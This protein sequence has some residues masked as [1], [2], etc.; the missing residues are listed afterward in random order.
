M[1]FGGVAEERLQL[2]E[3]TL[4]SGYPG[5]RDLPLDVRKDLPRVTD[6]IA[7]RQFAEADRLVTQK[8]LGASWACYQPLGDLFFAFEHQ[9]S[10]TEY[11]REL[12][13]ANAVCRVRYRAGDVRFTREIFAS[14]PDEVIVVR[15]TAD[16]PGRLNF[17]LWLTS[18]HPVEVRADAARLVMHGQLPGLV[19]RRTLDWVEKKGDTWKYPELWDKSGR[20]L[21]GAGQVLYNGRGMSFDARLHLR[22]L[23]GKVSAEKKSLIVTGA[24]EAVVIYTAASSYGGFEQKPVDAAR[25]ADGFLRSAMNAK[26]AELLARH[27]RDY[28][29][30]FDRVKLDLGPKPN[31]PT[32][33]RLKK[34]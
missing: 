25:K 21:P 34:P 5:Y 7:R 28:R 18:P 32:D 20:R 6:L 23:G 19:L 1:V 26:Y 13:L 14:H 15:F 17:R 30:L 33:E 2:N 10:A 4:V 29:G 11:T 22:T 31:L 27:R 24:D 3:A 12:D 9:G 16:K 8:W